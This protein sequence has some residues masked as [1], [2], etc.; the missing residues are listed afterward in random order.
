M[1]PQLPSAGVTLDAAGNIYGTGY[2]GG[3]FND[4][5]V[6]EL[7]PSGST[8]T[9]TIV[10]AFDYASN[11]DGARPAAN[12]VFDADGNLYGTTTM[13]GKSKLGI[14]GLGTV[15]KLT[16]SSSGWTE[17]IIHNF[18]GVD[19]QQPQAG[20]IFDAAGNM[21]GT[22]QQGGASGDGIVFEITP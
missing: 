14:S 19:G 5:V 6:F 2:I 22:T 17:T 1:D 3:Q 20:V 8:W 13:G 10:H 4:G 9:E 16:P 11:F 15:F 18:Q 21:Y 7:S 12:L